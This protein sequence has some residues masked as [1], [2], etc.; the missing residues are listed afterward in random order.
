MPNIL[1]NNYCNRS[2]VYCFAKDKIRGN[3]EKKN[4]NLDNI[5][6]IIGFLKKSNHQFFSVLGGE[7]TL[8]PQFTKIVDRALENQLVVRVFS[9]GLMKKET[10]KYI[11]RNNI[12]VILNI[13]ELKDTPLSQCNKL[14]ELYD[15]IGPNIYPGFNIYHDGFDFSFIFDLIDKYHM[16]REIRLGI[17]QPIFNKDNFFVPPTQYQKIGKKIA[18]L[19]EDASKKNI[20]INLDCGYIL[21]MFSEIDI[22]KLIYSNAD[23]NFSCGPIIDIDPELNV[24][25][26]FPLSSIANRNLR[27]FD[28]LESVIN[29]YEKIKGNLLQVGI[30]SKCNSCQYLKRHQCS[31]GCIS[32]KI[33]NYPQ[34][35]QRLL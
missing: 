26:C 7:P 35:L 14:N 30:F 29:Y 8:H 22:G 4:I 10:Q 27:E 20:K 32:H 25:H 28:N 24:W 3:N 12:N 31:G 16:S 13:N 2:C 23:V 34:A 5:D 6:Y 11:F 1:L 9:N 19:A 17:S 33:I 15:N 21:C 18:I